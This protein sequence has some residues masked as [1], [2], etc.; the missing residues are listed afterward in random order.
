MKL[1][2]QQQLMKMLSSRG[3]KQM[4]PFTSPM[5]QL[6][7]KNGKVMPKGKSSSKAKV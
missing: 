2:R 3:R 7:R 4:K 5:N 6:V 1:S